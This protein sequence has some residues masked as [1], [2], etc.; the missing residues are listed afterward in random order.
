MFAA[1]YAEKKVTPPLGIDLTGFGFYLH[2]RAES[3]LD[4]LKVRALSLRDTT[5]GLILITCDLLGFTVPFSDKIRSRIAS[6]QKMPPQNILLSCTHTHSGPATQPLP[7]LGKV[8]PDYLRHLGQAIKEAAAEASASLEEAKFGF[9]FE[10]AEPI[11]YNRRL[12]NFEEVDP[13][14]KAAIFKQKRRKIFLLSYACHP[15]TLGPTKEI[16]ADWPG[17]LIREIEGRG[18]CGLVFQGFCGDIDPVTYL[19]R[20]LGATKEDIAL[21]G[22]ILAERALKCERYV[23]FEARPKLRA[24]EKRIR[25]PLQVFPKSGL[26]QETRAA[27]EATKKFPRAG[28]IIRSWR[29]KVEKCHAV[30]SRAPWL[31]D[32]PVQALGI[33]DLRIL[34]LP[35]EVFSGLG[36]RLREKWPSL[37]TIGYANGNAGYLP[38]REAFRT[39]NDYACYCAPQFYSVFPFSPETESVLFRAGNALLSSL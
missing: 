23:S 22:K 36:M 16:S 15:V 13:W 39:P 29:R 31:E 4:D 12:R 11:G 21:S 26:E 9:H 24:A 7:G 38:T 28:R 30:F 6:D 19:N 18:H 20:R 35:G 34:G 37:M 27:V 2:R 8:D 5:H 25:L 10:A 1:G 14:L 33:G 32:V 17:A 3:V